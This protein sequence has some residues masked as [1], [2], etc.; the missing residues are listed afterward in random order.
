[1]RISLQGYFDL[2]LSFGIDDEPFHN[3]QLLD[4]LAKDI[5]LHI[6]FPLQIPDK[7]SIPIG[8]GV[9]ID[10]K[11]TS[12][13]KEWVNDAKSKIGLDDGLDFFDDLIIADCFL[14]IYSIGIGF[15]R[16][17]LDNIANKNIDKLNL[18]SDCFTEASFESFASNVKNIS[19][20]FLSIFNHCGLIPRSS[21]R[22]LLV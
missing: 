19:A 16:L 1:M 10:L 6:T 3:E 22:L 11:N 9:K 15:Y 2:G 8:G 13:E 20:K 7:M 14:V 12:V 5:D 18:L 17:D 21:L 4:R